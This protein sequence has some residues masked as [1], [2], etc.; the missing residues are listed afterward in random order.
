[1][2]MNLKQ[3]ITC[4]GNDETASVPLGLEQEREEGLDQSQLSDHLRYLIINNFGY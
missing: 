1:M 3:L 4:I 2:S